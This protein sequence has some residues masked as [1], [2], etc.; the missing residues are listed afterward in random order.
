[1]GGVKGAIG[2][3]PGRTFIDT[4][5][6]GLEVATKCSTGGRRTLSDREDHRAE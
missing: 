2:V 5:A 1:M 6:M 4:I 3:E